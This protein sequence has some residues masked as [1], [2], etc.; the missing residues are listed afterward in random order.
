MKVYL[1][2][3]GM[4]NP[5]TLTVGAQRA[6]DD[7][8]LLIGAR[9]L[10]EP[11]ADSPA[12]KL[13]LIKASE[14]AAA[15]DESE[16]ETVS[17]L[18]SGDIGFYSGATGL[19]GK[20][21]KHE[22]VSIPGISSLVYFCAKLHTPWQ[23]AHLV[24]AHG[25][26]HNALGAIQAHAK[27]FLLTGGATKA[28][29]VCASLVE[30]GLQDV[31]VHAGERLS[32]DDERIVTGTAAELTGSEFADLTVLLV[33]N[34]HPID[35]SFAAPS[36]RDEDFARGR[37][38]MTKEE[39][40]E[41]SICKLR[42]MPSSIVWDVGAG[43][44]S[45]SIEAALAACEGLVYAIE[46]NA[47]A[48]ETLE[49]NRMRFGLSNLHIVAGE[50]PEALADLPAP[51]HV[52]VGG[53]S[54]QMEQIMR[55]ALSKNPTVRFVVNAITLETL[56]EALRCLDALSLED[57]DIVQ[58]SC[59]RSKEV[60]SYHMMMA[61]N[62]V[63]IVSAYGEQAVDPAEGMSS[64]SSA[65]LPRDCSA[66][67]SSGSFGQIPSAASPAGSQNAQEPSC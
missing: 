18:L 24:S 36:L 43:T 65:S 51:S 12:V 53:S 8:E 38:P 52:F 30:H 25:R 23:D 57:V 37:A 50:A 10:L 15:L 9:R 64:S 13:P 4:G 16:F 62:P 32:Y 28:S 20:L 44:G 6:I 67:G 17:V 45:I 31:V 60:G 5:D 1:I 14:I 34:P 19:Y 29:D 47:E 55:C 40:R 39:V 54:G 59:A 49:E 21:G 22:V 58:V 66:S 35:R 48:L 42:L 33:E 7:S 27:T 56:S 11:Y 61:N 41:L 26:E 46:K 63:Y 3:I 2:G